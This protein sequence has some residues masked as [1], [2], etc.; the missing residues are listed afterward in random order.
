[1]IIKVLSIIL[2]NW[3]SSRR[4]LNPLTGLDED[5][6]RFSHFHHKFL[7]KTLIIQPTGVKISTK[8]T[9][10]TSLFFS[11]QVTVIQSDN[12]SLKQLHSQINT[13]PNSIVL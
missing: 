11:T 6:N 12:F 13:S 10:F 9:A 3:L 7:L 5:F 8:L 2:L 1:M 4:N